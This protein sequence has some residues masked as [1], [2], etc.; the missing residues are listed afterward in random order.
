[1][2]KLWSFAIAALIHA[3]LLV[4]VSS[5]VA[6]DSD[7][8]TREYALGVRSASF[9]RPQQMQITG[10]G[11]ANEETAYFAK[12]RS[13]AQWRR[14]ENKFIEMTP[15][16]ESGKIS[17]FHLCHHRN[18]FFYEVKGDGS[19]IIYEHSVERWHDEAPRTIW[20][21]EDAYPASSLA[22]VDK[23]LLRASESD[24]IAIDV[25]PKHDDDHEHR[26]LDVSTLFE[27]GPHEG[28]IASVAVG[29]AADVV[30]RANIFA[31][32]PGNGTLVRLHLSSDLHE[33][34]KLIA[35]SEPFLLAGDGSD[36]ALSDASAYDPR[37]VA[38]VHGTV[39]FADGCA[40]RQIADGRVKT[41]IGVPS[42][43]TAPQ[44]ETV[45]PVPWASR[46]SKAMA[47]AGVAEETSDRTVLA[48]TGDR[49]SPAHEV[50]HVFKV[51]QRDDSCS[52][53]VAEDECTTQQ[54]CAWAIGA[55]EI[56]R[57]C[58]S[59]EALDEWI[60]GQHDVGEKCMLEM[61]PRFGTNY[62]LIGC[63]CV[64]PTPVPGSS[65]FGLTA[66]Q[67]LVGGAV[68]LAACCVLTML[69][70]ASRRAAAPRE[71]LYEDCAEFHIFTDC[72]ED[73]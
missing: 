38:S 32:V 46:L 50:Q 37:H 53:H 72:E 29:F 9:Y 42:R 1:M 34:H 22:C 45:E 61:Q 13:V 39:L 49:S 69:H 28:H 21:S 23:Y 36:G 70:R 25:E 31:A 63:G 8:S 18:S 20:Q 12:T 67:I 44:N 4:P 60:R 15:P 68:I 19:V 51:T 11:L 33:D 55:K 48:L 24:L 54:G 41:L 64:A 16:H 58:F 52:E 56:E 27:Y 43:C 10:I 30:S 17:A 59:C 66:F 57:L 5:S 2:W 35:Q 7:E 65:D 26:P 3:I 62:N 47:L 6:D 40:L 73:R 14:D 71:L